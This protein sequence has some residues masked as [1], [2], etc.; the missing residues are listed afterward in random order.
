MIRIKFF[1]DFFCGR[2]S[3][4]DDLG[5]DVLVS[6]PLRDKRKIGSIGEDQSL[7]TIP[8]GTVL[9]RLSTLHRDETS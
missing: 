2:E 1:G 5:V 8:S 7:K 3:L 4:V 9:S 6:L